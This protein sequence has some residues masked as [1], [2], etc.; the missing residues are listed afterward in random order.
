MIQDIFMA[1]PLGVLLCFLI[2]PVFFI[3]LE[4]AATKGFRAAIVFDLGVVTA[5]FVFIAIA[6]FSSYRLINAIKDQPALYIFGG[7]IMITYG[8][9]SF[10]K[11]KKHSANLDESEENIQL[12]LVKKD[13]RSLYFKG[14]F[15]NFINVGVLGF[16]FLIFLT[17]APVLQLKTPRLLI[18]FSSVIIT[19]LLVDIA[20]M[21]L[22][23]KL[24]SK[25]TPVNILKI[26][27]LTSVL[28]IVFGISIMLQGWFP[29]D[30]KLVK[31]ALE[32]IEP[33]K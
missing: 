31:Q 28:L 10:L 23:K 19:Y 24:K 12:E 26:K 9:I 30:Q 33:K 16:W 22:A 29:A 15:L 7:L 27:K 20:K 2:G 21:M 11:L 25:M 1:I 18:F 6:V 4:T 8:V 14:F 17:F 5:D 3:V 13:Y 32:K